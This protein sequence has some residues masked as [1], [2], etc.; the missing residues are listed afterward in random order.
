MN[1]FQIASDNAAALEQ[2]TNNRREARCADQD[3]LDRMQ[4]FCERVRSDGRI[5]V[6]MRPWIL[7]LPPPRRLQEHLRLGRGNGRTF[8]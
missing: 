4:R 7:A 8:G 1:L 2:Q 3:A 5:A 6:N